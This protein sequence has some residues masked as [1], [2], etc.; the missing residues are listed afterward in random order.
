MDGA[1]DPNGRQRAGAVAGRAACASGACGRCRCREGGSFPREV[2]GRR[3]SARAVAVRR[4]VPV[5]GDLDH[6][7]ARSSGGETGAKAREAR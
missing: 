3:G 4:A 7:E 5:P 1:G 6:A 2:G